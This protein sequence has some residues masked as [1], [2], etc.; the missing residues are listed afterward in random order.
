SFASGTGNGALGQQ[1]LNTAGEAVSEFAFNK[2]NTLISQSNTI[3]SLDLNIRSF[4][5]ASASLRLFNERFVL[6]GSL[7]STT[8]NSSDLLNN[9]TNLFNSSFNNLSKDFSAQ[10]LMTRNGNLTAR[11]SYRLLNGT[12]LNTIDQQL[13]AQYV[14]GLGLVYQR[15]FDTFGEFLRN[16]FGRSKKRQPITPLPEPTTPGHQAA[17]P[18]NG[19]SGGSNNEEPN[20]Q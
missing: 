10:Y 8:N 9:N 17:A 18:G 14:N 1:T 3:K 7:Y 20:D 5:D 12:I 2:L 6:S 16:I 13:T 15:D 11:Y 19:G 4:N